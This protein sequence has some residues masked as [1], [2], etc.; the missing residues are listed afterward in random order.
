MKKQINLDKWSRKE[1]FLFFSTF[2]EPFFGVTISLDCTLAYAKAKKIGQSFFLYYLYRA[3]QAANKIENFRYRI[4]ANQVF[5][6][7]QIHASPTVLR[8]NRTFGFAYINYEEEESI[9]I[10]NAEQEI[11]KTQLSSELLPAITGESVIHFSALPWLNFTSLSHARR[12]SFSDSAPKISFGKLVSLDDNKSMSVSIHV[13][14]ALVD[15]YHVGL[16]V[17]EFQRLMND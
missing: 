10:Q 15:G 13:H 11:K 12:F 5:L 14:H 8:A 6:Y 17:D 9:F 4:T 1:A 16:F 3:L 2:E 7:D